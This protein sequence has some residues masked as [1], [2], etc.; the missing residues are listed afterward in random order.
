LQPYTEVITN[1]LTMAN[2]GQLEKY[3]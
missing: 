1:A 3:L 2:H